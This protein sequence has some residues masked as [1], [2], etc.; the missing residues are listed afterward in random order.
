MK[1][2]LF[3]M[4]S[5]LIGLGTGLPTAQAENYY[6]PLLCPIED[7]LLLVENTSAEPQSFWFQ[8]LGSF[9]FKESH[10]EVKAH[11]RLRLVLPDDHQEVEGGVA[12]KTQNAQLSFKTQCK[13]THQAHA[14][15]K[16]ITPWKQLQL[17]QPEPQIQL[18][19]LNLAQQENL[20]EISY[21][22]VGMKLGSQS[23]KLGPDF[24]THVVHL[25]PPAGTKEVRLRAQGRWTGKAL[26]AQG[27]DLTLQEEFSPRHLP[28][29]GTRYFLF[30]AQSPE[31]RESFVV[32]M[33]DP[34]LIAESLQ[35]LRH[36]ASARLL[37]A[38]IEKSLSGVNRDFSSPL[39]TPWS[40]QVIQAQN[41]ADFAHI[42]CDG[43][44]QLV[45][46]RLNSW[47]AE[48]GGTICFW[49]YRIQREL[50]VQELT[51]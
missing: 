1:A 36:P 3:F 27:K 49:N 22:A 35:Q 2:F 4:L 5:A 17:P 51:N 10:I 42:S 13:N 43:S 8:A 21:R 34:K 31:P 6:T 45:E 47:L 39:K 15:S 25:T 29:D 44:P 38:R 18:R 32:P 37:V 48:T 40:W 9:P 30:Q 7:S 14:L 33:N 50:S 24:K 26:T 46:E 19:I 11:G 16:S 20:L 23:L 41:Y 12:L 28:P